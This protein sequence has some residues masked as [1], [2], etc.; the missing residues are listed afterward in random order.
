ME[1]EILFHLRKFAVPEIVFG[2]GA[3]ELAGKH[4]RNFGASRVLLVTDEG[5][6]EA[7]WTARAEDALAREGLSS[8]RFEGLTPNPKDSEVMAG[9]EACQNGECDLILA[10]GGGSPMDCAK[11]ISVAAGNACHVLELEGVDEIPSP[12]VPLI[13]VPT[14]AGT[15]ADVS[16]FAIITDTA[17]KRKVALVSKMVIPEIALVDPDTT[18]TLSQEVVADSGM[19]ALSHSVEAH[20]STLSSPLTDMA[21]REA[22]RLAS[23]NLLGAYEDRGHEYRENMMMASLMAGLAFS[24]ASLGLVHAMAHSL[25]GRRD[26]E[27]GRCN[28]LLLEEVVRYNARVVP[29]KYAE[30]GR[31]VDPDCASATD[32]EA[33]QSLLRCLSALRRGLGISKGLG[34]MGLTREEIPGL[35]EAAACEPCMATNP[36]RAD[37]EDIERLLERIL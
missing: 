34:E 5:V 12:G 1:S 25:G 28:A 19:D 11:G 32:S 14:T 26:L 21:A 33:V 24:N 8:V 37:R 10:V 29:G 15:S 18:Q 30:L 20:A 6:R 31:I 17:G 23:G 22:V 16:Q 35:A 13:C 7:G 4:C 36:V 27:H 9:V 3:L 2:S